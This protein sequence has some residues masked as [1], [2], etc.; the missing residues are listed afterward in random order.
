[1][2]AMPWEKMCAHLAP[3]KALPKRR[4]KFADDLSMAPAPSLA[5]RTASEGQAAKAAW[6]GFGFSPKL[7]ENV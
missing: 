5:A 1:M 6:V 7:A 4:T 2:L 3:V